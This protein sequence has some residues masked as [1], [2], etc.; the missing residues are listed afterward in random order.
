MGVSGQI[1]GP[2][3]LP[4]ERETSNRLIGGL[5]GSRF[6]EEGFGEEKRPL[7]TAEN[8]KPGFLRLS[9]TDK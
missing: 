7:T 2:T 4:P 3:D 6:G 9:T 8:S 1:H 5:M